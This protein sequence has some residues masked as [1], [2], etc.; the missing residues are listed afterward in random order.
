M[1]E[2]LLKNITKREEW[3][4]KN[5][6]ENAVVHKKYLNKLFYREKKHIFVK[7]ELNTIKHKVKLQM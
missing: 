3:S 1:N 5:Y 7:I 6:I 2:I 4:K